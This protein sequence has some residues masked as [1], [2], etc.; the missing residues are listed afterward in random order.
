MDPQIDQPKNTRRK[1]ISRVV[2]IVATIGLL[3]VLVATQD[4][5][6]A[7]AR[8]STLS[9]SIAAIAIVLFALANACMGFRWW[10][11]LRGLGSRLPFHWLH[12]TVYVGLSASLVLPSSI[13]GDAVRGLLARSAGLSLKRAATSLVVDRALG[14]AALGILVVVLASA[15]PDGLVPPMVLLAARVLVGAAAVGGLFLV[16]RRATSTKIRTLRT[17]W[18]YPAL[19]IAII[20]HVATLSAL[21]ALSRS[22]GIDAPAIAIAACATMAWLAALAPITVGGLG[23]REA[24]LVTMLERIGVPADQALAATVLWT[25]AIAVQAVVGSIA[26]PDEVKATLKTEVAVEARTDDGA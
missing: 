15:I 2:R 26:M 23:V 18:L 14:V 11:V 20:A 24:V 7:W 12:R 25:A 3:G 13:G 9:P 19:G 10:L 5:S 6:E 8:L 1:T 16:W 17:R 22:V 21:I 4:L